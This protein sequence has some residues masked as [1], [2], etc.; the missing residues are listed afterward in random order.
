MTPYELNKYLCA[1][2]TTLDEVPY[3]PESS[4]YIA[5]GMDM[6]KWGILKQVLIESDLATFHGYA[7]YIT[8]AGKSLAA[9]INSSM[10]K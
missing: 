8:P 10:R 3:A 7:A 1:I 6:E 9:M 4:L 5:M 2:I